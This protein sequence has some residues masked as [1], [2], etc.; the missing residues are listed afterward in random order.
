MIDVALLGHRSLVT[1]A[2]CLIV[3]H[4]VL[5]LDVSWRLEVS[6]QSRIVRLALRETSVSWC[7]MESLSDDAMMSH[8]WRLIHGVS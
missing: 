8:A 7:L 4:H 3:S 2:W 6:H 5:S 1:H